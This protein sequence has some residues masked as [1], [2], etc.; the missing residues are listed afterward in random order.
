MRREIIIKKLLYAG[1]IPN[2]ITALSQVIFVN[3]IYELLI[4]LMSLYLSPIIRLRC[5]YLYVR[6][7]LLIFSFISFILYLFLM[8]DWRKKIILCCW[9][10][11][12][13]LC[14]ITI[15]AFINFWFSQHSSSPLLSMRNLQIRFNIIN[16]IECTARRDNFI[17]IEKKNFLMLDKVTALFFCVRGNGKRKRMFNRYYTHI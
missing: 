7:Y 5:R 16:F 10:G 14:H 13:S 12:K 6:V 15:I 1:Y 17:S 8:N 2:E 9:M 4:R 11:K 3:I